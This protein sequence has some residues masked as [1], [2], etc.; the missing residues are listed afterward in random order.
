MIPKISSAGGAKSSIF[1]SSFS[2]KI[3]P[4]QSKLDILDMTFYFLGQIQGQIRRHSQPAFTA[5][6]IQMDALFYNLIFQHFYIMISG[7]ILIVN[8]Q[9]SDFASKKMQLV[10]LGIENMKCAQKCTYLI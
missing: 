7:K 4:K 6:C 2:D 1:N 5:I 10:A 9:K 8:N 3:Q